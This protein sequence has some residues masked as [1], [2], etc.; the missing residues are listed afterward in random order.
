VLGHS[1]ASP[2]RLVRIA[3]LD[4][5]LGPCGVCLPDPRTRGRLDLDCG[6]V[7]LVD[8]EHGHSRATE[9]KAR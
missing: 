9:D 7:Q 4:Q 6:S 8:D 1:T 3:W 2:V 5:A